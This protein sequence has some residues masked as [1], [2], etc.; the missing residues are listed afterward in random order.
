MST[1]PEQVITFVQ[2]TAA[3]KTLRELSANELV[4]AVVG[5]VGSGTS[6][7]A[8]A[9]SSLLSN[10]VYGVEAHV[11]K[12]SNAITSWIASTG[13][14]PIQT[15]DALTKV[16]SLQDAGD[17]MR[18]TDHAAVAVALIEAI[19]TKRSELNATVGDVVT[20]IKQTQGP[21]K[22]AYILDSLKHPAEVEL[23]RTIYQ[24]AFCL[25]GVVC[26]GQI[27]QQRLSEEKCQTS[28]KTAIQEVMKRDEDAE[29]K[30]G[31][32][33]ADTFH[34]A[35][36]FVDNSPKR[37]TDAD[38]KTPNPEW[39]VPDQLARLVDLITHQKVIRPTPSET[40]MFHAYGAKMRSACLSRQVGAALLD[41][42]GNIISTGTN[43]VPRGGGGV[44][45]GSFRDY[46]PSEHLSDH[47][48][49]AVNKYCSSNRSQDEI[50][51]EIISQ[52][53]ALNAVTDKVELS[54]QLKKT[55]IG[56]L[57]EFSRA[58]HAEMDALLS[59]ARLGATTVATRL[60]VTT[61]PCH[62]CARHIVSAGVDEVQY[63]E[64]YPKSRA[65]K[66]HGDAITES[67]GNWMAPSSAIA[68]EHK[69]LFRPFT[70]VA[71]R[72]YRQVFLKDR[73]LK[74]ENGDFQIGEADSATGLLKV[75]YQEIEN[76]LLL[77]KKEG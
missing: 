77:D 67:P 68:T 25:V 66:L 17:L 46:D 33:V 71:P 32:K 41:K 16:K 69:V 62:Y 1:S 4:F 31:Q 75:G 56:K 59:A 18:K 53:P 70:G 11:I 36:F 50:I 42:N 2:K 64:P 13:N 27:R 37:F 47:R 40:G 38:K 34:L 39:I 26:E 10:Q 72:I 57:L 63:I 51:N 20:E 54:K 60:F 61:F 12:A 21:K 28:G 35:D 45:G 65:L 49:V 43:E 30:H 9:L 48:C 29:I 24:D 74:N 6:F 22:R 58:V 44:Y 73:K 5:P 52:I 76:A 3:D 23:L 8:N 19:R 15:T 55:P 7:V 14:A